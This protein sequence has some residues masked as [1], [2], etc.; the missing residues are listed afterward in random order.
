MEHPTF[1]MPGPDGLYLCEQ[2]KEWFDGWHG[3]QQGSGQNRSAEE[4]ALRI[5]RN[6]GG[7]HSPSSH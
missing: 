4:E 2:I 7:P 1:P 3:R 6:G 5:A